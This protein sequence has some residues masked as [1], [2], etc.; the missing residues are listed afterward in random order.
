[1]ADN[2]VSYDYVGEGPVLM[3]TMISRRTEGLDTA[4]LVEKLLELADALA[5][6]KLY[7]YQKDFA[8]AVLYSVIEREAEE[9]S[10]LF[11]RQS[12][13][14]QTLSALGG[15]LMIMMPYF[16]I[17]F[18]E[19]DRF[20]YYDRKSESTRSYRDGFWIGVF[21]PKKEQAGIIFNRVKAFLQRDVA[22]AVLAEAGLTFT[23]NNGD[24]VRLSNG[25]FIKSSSASDQANIEGD[26]F[27]LGIEDESQDISDEKSNKSIGP[28]LAA[29]GGTR[30]KIGTANARKSHFYN[31][32]RR[33]VRREI[34]GARKHHFLVRWEVAAARN[35]FYAKYVE[36]EALRL[37]RTSD[38]FRMAYC[39][40]F[41]LERSQGIPEAHFNNR[42]VITGP[43]SDIIIRRRRGAHYVAG[44]DFGKFHDPTVVT[45]LEVDWDNPRQVLEAQDPEKGSIC[46]ELFGKH[47]CDWLELLG[48]DYEAQMVTIQRF[49]KPW[50][51]ERLCL[52]YTGV[53]VALG[54]RAMSLFSPAD[55]VLVPLSDDSNDRL[56]RQLLADIHG[57]YITWPGGPECAQRHE[58]KQFKKEALDV[59]KQ[60]NRGL[61]K[62]QHPELRN[63]HD[64]YIYSLMLGV[65]AASSRPFGGEVEED[66]K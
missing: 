7:D 66:Y 58:F 40:E 48:D 25:S 23:T 65:D 53:G 37:G 61:L 22:K 52:D 49:L 2:E 34:E 35:S 63:A 16:A 18:P 38:E 51:V 29:T 5:G 9:I 28:M 32:C 15:S 46:L 11:A 45:L 43:Y 14:S 19:D 60:Y 33:N 26:T 42:T 57:G 30:V 47:V 56:A 55:V 39:C 8:R 6:S 3:D 31:T 44:V 13:K 36:K 1:M 20:C 50:G 17:K 27:H 64:D 10:A 54:D 21:A 12:G 41:M 4:L 24:R 59:E 62:L